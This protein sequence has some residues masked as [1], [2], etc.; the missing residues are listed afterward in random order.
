MRLPQ[1]R[2]RNVDDAPPKVR[3]GEV[4]LP[5]AEMLAIKCRKL[6]CHPGLGMYAIC[7]T[8]DRHLMRRN[9]RPNVFPQ[10]SAHFA[11]QFADAIRV[12][13]EA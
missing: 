11:V 2:V 1:L 13:A 12:P 9:A 5:I 8:G 4:L 6:G 3:F 10:G 7:D